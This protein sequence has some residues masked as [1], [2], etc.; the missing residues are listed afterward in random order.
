MAFFIASPAALV[1]LSESA[2][3]VPV[4][5]LD[6][7]DGRDD[8]CTSE[9]D[10]LW[11]EPFIAFIEE[12]VAQR[13]HTHRFQFSTTERLDRHLLDEI[14]S[15]HVRALLI[16][17][18][19][20]HY[21]DWRDNDVEYPDYDD[22]RDDARSYC[23]ECESGWEV[24]HAE[25]DGPR[26]EDVPAD[27]IE[28][29]E[30][31]SEAEHQARRQRNLEHQSERRRR[32]EAQEEAESEVVDRNFICDEECDGF[33]DCIHDRYCDAFAPNTVALER[34]WE[35]YLAER[36]ERDFPPLTAAGR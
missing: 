5:K 31:I 18:I 10:G 22:I 36:G 16:E 8:Y 26:A 13:A 15:T 35:E 24:I 29:A 32:R 2:P 12:R 20:V 23:E 33:C 4:P 17:F 34:R 11:I 27:E 3:D 28:H 14:K 25:Y 30:G 21:E 7:S 19:N 9:G 6:V 1:R